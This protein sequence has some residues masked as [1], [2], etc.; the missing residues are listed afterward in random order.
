M[1]L[2]VYFIILETLIIA[3]QYGVR[4]WHQPPLTNSF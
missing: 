2:K 1:L 3:Y 4:V